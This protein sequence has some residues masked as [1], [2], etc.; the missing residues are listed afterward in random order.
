[1]AKDP[2]ARLASPGRLMREIDAAYPADA[3]AGAVATAPA[4]RRW[5]PRAGVAALA[6]G[7]VALGIAAGA[8]AGGASGSDPAPRAPKQMRAADLTLRYPADWTVSRTAAAVPGLRLADAVSLSPAGTLGDG[9]LVAGRVAGGAL[10]ATGELVDLGQVTGRRYSGLRES[11]SRRRVV[12]YAVPGAGGTVVAAC[13]QE[14]AGGAFANRCRRAASTLRARQPGPPLRAPNPRYSRQMAAVVGRVERVRARGRAALARA[15]TRGGQAGAA[16]RLRR[17]YR[18]LA[19]V[20]AR[21]DAPG[22]ARSPTRTAVAQL[23]RASRGFGDMAH[24]ARTERT[25]SW[26]AARRGV[27]SAE[28][29]FQAALRGL[30]RLGYDVG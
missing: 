6:A 30:R 23:R 14:G 28:G 27:R 19:A 24:A 1:M 5:R 10:P 18:T 21:I 29:R 17:D 2:A 3:R 9:E 16:R 4:E 12:A 11:G 26:N 13:F 22:G 7:L 20:M 15:R 8:L 25:G